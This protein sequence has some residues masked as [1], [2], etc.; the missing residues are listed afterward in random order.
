MN[1]TNTSNVFSHRKNLI[2]AVSFCLILIILLK[3]LS[4]LALIAKRDPEPIF[5]CDPRIIFQEPENTIDV[6]TIGNSNVRS[7][8]IPMQLWK[9]YGI[10]S[11]TWGEPS[12]DPYDS[13]QY[14]KKIF[15]KQS[16]SVVILEAS[17]FFRTTSFADNLNSM[18]RAKLSDMF[19]LIPYHSSLLKLFKYGFS[20][21]YNAN[22]SV[23]KGYYVNFQA[24]PGKK[25]SS[26]MN[27]TSSSDDMIS[28]LTQKEI[29]RI[30]Q[31]CKDHGAKLIIAA[32][33]STSDWGYE[34]HQLTKKFCEDNQL[35]FL[36]MNTTDVLKEMNLNWKKDT[37]DGGTHMNYTGA[38]LVTDYL[39]KYLTEHYQ[40]T[41]FRQDRNYEQWNTDCEYF[42][43]TIKQLRNEHT[44]S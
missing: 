6:I 25:G 11:Y 43:D 14:L 23:T 39:G 40:L 44:A 37:R 28:F 36:D 19:P 20:E 8:I 1:S 2:K 7:G 10:T 3:L 35:T 13:E 22:H 4:S 33:P 41:D 26:Y 29:L 31:L 12:V 32:V 15:R 34:R 21:L 18:T 27:E 42:Y 30:E 9:D 16:P 5:N 38:S 17:F 24:K